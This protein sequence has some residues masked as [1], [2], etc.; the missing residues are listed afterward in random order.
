MPAKH[1]TPRV[2]N[3]QPR[4]RFNSTEAGIRKLF[5]GIGL[6]S[7]NKL[8]SIPQALSIGGEERFSFSAIRIALKLQRVIPIFE[9]SRS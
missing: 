9:E 8:R 1:P 2:P 4:I 3:F 6:I 5:P 7:G